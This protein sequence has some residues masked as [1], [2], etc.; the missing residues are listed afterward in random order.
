MSGNTLVIVL[1]LTVCSCA[2]ISVFLHI[3]DY[4]FLKQRQSHPNLL[5]QRRR[6][7]SILA[8]GQIVNIRETFQREEMN[9]SQ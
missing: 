8:A 5:N 1:S 6:M 9:V 7:H 2:F 3:W 4:A